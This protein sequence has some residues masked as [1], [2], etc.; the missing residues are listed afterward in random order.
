MIGLGILVAI[1]LLGFIFSRP[2]SPAWWLFLAVLL[3]GAG[4]FA[5]VVILAIRL[6]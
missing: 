1:A 3:M 5:Y 4:L 6:G 2:R